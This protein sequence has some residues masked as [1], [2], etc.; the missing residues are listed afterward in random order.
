MFICTFAAKC[1][2]LSCFYLLMYSV[3]EYIKSALQ[4]KCVMTIISSSSGGSSTCM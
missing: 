3:F 4:I 2:L 1:F